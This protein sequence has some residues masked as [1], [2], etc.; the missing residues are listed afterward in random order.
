MQEVRRMK[1]VETMERITRQKF[2]D[3]FDEILDRV[4]NG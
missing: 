1:S 3:N 4:D 2:C